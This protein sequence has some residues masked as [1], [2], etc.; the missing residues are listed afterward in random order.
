LNLDFNCIRSAHRWQL[1]R[2]W[3]VQIEIADCS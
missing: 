1:N 2:D 3:K